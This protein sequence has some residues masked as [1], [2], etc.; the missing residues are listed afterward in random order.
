MKQIVKG[1]SPNDFDQ[2]KNDFAVTYGRQ[3][4]Y[5]DLLGDVKQNLKY[6]LLQEQGHICCY[7]TKELD[8]ECHIEHFVP[9]SS[10]VRSGS[11]LTLDYDNMLV[12]CNGEG[13]DRSSCGHYKNN[14][15]FDILLSP[16]SSEVEKQFEYDVLGNI[17][18]ATASASETIRWLNLNSFALKR[19]RETAIYNCGCMDEDFEDI[20]DE[21][22]EE[23][24]SRDEHGAFVPYCMAILF[25]IR[26]GIRD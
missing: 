22:I 6:A 18:G 23:Y 9:Q 19:H 7:C 11:L 26:C 3:P 10:T 5:D 2:W 17:L 4:T 14:V 1:S 12:S 13:D 20:R 21:L 8:Y 25:I 24:S 16:T 15:D